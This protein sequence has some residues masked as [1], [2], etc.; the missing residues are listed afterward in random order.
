MAD[1]DAAGSSGRLE[2]F[3]DRQIAAADRIDGG[4][5]GFGCERVFDQSAGRPV[6]AEALADVD[7]SETRI[8]LAQP[9]AK[10]DL[11]LFL[12]AKAIAADRDQDLGG[13]DAEPFADEIGRGLPG[14]AIVDADIRDAV[15]I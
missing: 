11:A 4:D 14:D 9:P 6:D 1:E 15:A 10:A 2:G 12:A 5:L 7:R 13:R 8:A 3:K